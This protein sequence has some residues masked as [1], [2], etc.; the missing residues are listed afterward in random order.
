MQCKR[1]FTKRF[2]LFAQT[3]VTPFYG[4]IHKKCT[5]LAAIARYIAINYKIDY[6]Q[7][8]QAGC[9]LT[10]KQIAMGFN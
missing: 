8:F 5:S 7:M 9:F 6:L 3:E 10:K 2:I 4:N 1:T